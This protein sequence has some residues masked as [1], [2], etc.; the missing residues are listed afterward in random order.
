MGSSGCE[1]LIFDN[2]NV[3]SNVSMLA[4]AHTPFSSFVLTASKRNT[5]SN[6][7]RKFLRG[8]LAEVPHNSLIPIQSLT[9]ISFL[10]IS[11]IEIS[12]SN[13]LVMVWNPV[14]LDL[15]VILG[16]PNTKLKWISI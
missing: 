10:V 16:I 1:C 6:I 14:P 2:G 3:G 15:G 5:C 8:I 13:S 4:L 11:H 7:V 12:N 9:H